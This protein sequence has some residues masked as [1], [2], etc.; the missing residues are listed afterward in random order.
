MDLGE[1]DSQGYENFIEEFSTLVFL[2]PPPFIYIYAPT[3]LRTACSVV[4]KVIRTCGSAY[5][6]RIHHARINAISCL[7]ARLL[8]DSILNALASWEASW[9]DG[10]ACWTAQNESQRWNE[11]TDTFLHGLQAL[12]SDLAANPQAGSSKIPDQSNIRFVIVIE[13]AEKLKGGLSDLIVPLTRL[14]ELVSV[15]FLDSEFL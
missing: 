14:A 12:Y 10:C 3:S 7:S 11:N 9:E 15:V 6:T 2:C 13:R 8:Y 5:T 4:D 1:V